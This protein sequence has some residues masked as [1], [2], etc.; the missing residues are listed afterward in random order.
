MRISEFLYLVL[1]ICF[2]FDCSVTSWIRTKKHNRNIG[3]KKGSLHTLGLAVDIVLDN[4]DKREDLLE[5]CHEN[6][7]HY[8]IEPDHIH[9]QTRPGKVN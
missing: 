4:P 7:L 6:V 5:F 3:G 8:Y 2:K 9:I 1:V